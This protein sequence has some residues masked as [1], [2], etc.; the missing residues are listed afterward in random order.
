VNVGF[1]LFVLAAAAFIAWTLGKPWLDRRRRQRL[2]A[3]P[4]PAAARALLHSRLALYRRVP[5]GLR[6]RLDALIS[7]FVGDKEFIGCQGLTVT[8]E[9]RYVIAAQASLLLLGRNDLGYDHLR[10]VLLYPSQFI[11]PEV[12]HDDDGVVQE[13]ERVLAGQAGGPGNIV[14]S[15]EDVE[16]GGHGDDGYNVVVHEFAHYLDEDEGAM[17]GA[18][19]LAGAAH[20][21]RWAEVFQHEFDSLRADADGGRDTFLDPYAA[22]DEAEFFAVVSETF[23]ETPHELAARHPALYRELVSFYRLDPAAW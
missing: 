21:E 7:E 18:P 8:D 2:R 10:S 17:N 11:V 5:D 19:P 3:T 4:L 1:A 16:Q 9:M 6:P 12:W 13:D 20:Y 22:Q 15:W 23:F 14:L